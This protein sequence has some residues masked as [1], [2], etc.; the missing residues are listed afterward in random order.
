[1]DLKLKSV[2]AVVRSSE[3]SVSQ[4]IIQRGESQWRH[5]FKRMFTFCVTME[6]ANKMWEHALECERVRQED[7]SLN[8][9]NSGKKF[10][11]DTSETSLEGTEASFLETRVVCRRKAAEGIKSHSFGACMH[12][13]VV[14]DISQMV[15][16]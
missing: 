14:V 10:K 4:W 12:L 1:M 11:R 2:K 5:E 7:V 15:L 16:V 3:L 8:Q 6:G 9:R 13:F